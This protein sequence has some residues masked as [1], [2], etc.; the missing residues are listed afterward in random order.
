MSAMADPEEGSAL[1][2]KKLAKVVQ[3]AMRAMTKPEEDLHTIGE[4]EQ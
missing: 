2:A 4:E 1:L 3:M